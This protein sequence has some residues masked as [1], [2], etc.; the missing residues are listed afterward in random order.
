VEHFFTGSSRLDHPEVVRRSI[1]AQLSGQYPELALQR[2]LADVGSAGQDEPSGADI[3]PV[4]GEFARLRAF[5]RRPLVIALAGVRADPDGG[6]SLSL[7]RLSGVTPPGVRYLVSTDDWAGV[8]R[9]LGPRDLRPV[10]LTEESDRRVC[11]AMVE[12]DRAVL[13]RAFAGRITGEALADLADNLPGNVAAILRWAALRSPGTASLDAVPAILTVRWPL[14]RAG[15]VERF[16]ED[17]TAVLLDVVRAADGL[18][19]W[20]DGE[21]VSALLDGRWGRF[22]SMLRAS[23]LIEDA[24]PD[25]LMRLAEP[26]IADRLRHPERVGDLIL[27]LADVDLDRS[28]R[29]LSRTRLAAAVFHAL[30]T[31]D[32]DTAVALCTTVSVLR[33]RY[34]EDV[35]G[36]LDDLA[37]VE[38][39]DGTPPTIP[40]LRTAIRGLA[41]EGV[42]PSAFTSALHDRLIELCGTPVWL[43]DDPAALA[44]LRVRQVLDETD[45]RVWSTSGQSG[46]PGPVLAMLPLSTGSGEPMLITPDGLTSM[47][48][49]PG[50]GSTG[51]LGLVG[52][53]RGLRGGCV[54]WSADTLHAAE[55]VE[56]SS[57]ELDVRLADVGPLDAHVDHAAALLNA[58]AVA[59]PDGGVTVWLVPRGNA[60]GSRRPWRMPG[61]GAGVTAVTQ[62]IPGTASSPGEPRMVLVASEDGLVR[63]L[64]AP[65]RPPTVFAGHRGAVRCL[66]TDDNPRTFFSGGDDGCVLEWRYDNPSRPVARWQAGDSPITCLAVLDADWVI[67]GAADGQVT[68]RHATTAE[69]VVLGGHAAAVRGIALDVSV[70]GT[71]IMMTWADSVRF[72]TPPPERSLLAEATG[73]PGGVRDVIAAGDRY[74][75]LCGDGSVQSRMMPDLRAPEPGD[76]PEYGCLAVHE[77]DVYFGQENNLVRLVAA[78][79]HQPLA[80]N[81]P[82]THA[83][84]TANGPVVR[85]VAGAVAHLGQDRSSV[86]T[87]DDLADADILATD[88]RDLVVTAADRFVRFQFGAGSR[89]THTLSPYD[90]AS[91]P[92]TSLAVRP[93]DDSP[94]DRT[95]TYSR[96]RPQLVIAGLANGDVQVVDVHDQFRARTLPG[97][98]VPITAVA[99]LA[100]GS[101]LTGSAD[102]DLRWWPDDPTHGPTTF[103]RRAGAITGIVAADPWVVS[104]GRDGRIVLWAT[105]PVRP[106]H[107]I[108]I[109]SPVVALAAAPGH[110]AARD[111]RGRLWL[112]DLD[113][114]NEPEGRPDGF[115][116]A[117]IWYPATDRTTSLDIHRR[118]PA[119]G[120]VEF[121]AVSVRLNGVPLP[122]TNRDRWPPLD[123]DGRFMEPARPLPDLPVR[124]AVETPPGWDGSPGL[125]VDLTLLSRRL[126]GYRALVSHPTFRGDQDASNINP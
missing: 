78:G 57:H 126:P 2:D 122:V 23:N 58:V 61:R 39:T 102:G 26:S 31:K 74:H 118:G 95:Q 81:G 123:P 43:A 69:S 110:V 27:G 73:F 112:L 42:P 47:A 38:A 119:G 36:L 20:L 22:W 11:L 72:W 51:G 93:P 124:L 111:E 49:A 13:D 66:V 7:L 29:R 108:T 10:V 65:D 85:N 80:S 62:L 82:Y 56:L 54:A 40:T 45:L 9:Y 15:L 25:E 12:R 17:R 103:P 59:A 16:G 35:T 75:V 92:V 114:P 5:D 67:A 44:P 50:S 52:A 77:G 105:D 48:A 109:G 6:S 87:A 101:V 116:L 121:A 117:P 24:R 97:D 115:E 86:P 60:A 33:R 4:L 120:A 94:A 64:A 70:I 104:A 71:E 1:L 98:G 41:A 99:G 63:L 79:G 106:V 46:H 55:Y 3:G 21:D 91:A 89:Y 19:T 32:I 30:E 76:H 8:A 34:A 28:V 37:A 107:E 83:G 53:V 18:H 125:T 100:D 96:P 14:V 68:A 84:V 88:G 90:T 113:D